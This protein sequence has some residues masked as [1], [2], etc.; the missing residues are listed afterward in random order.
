MMQVDVEGAL[1]Y[2][3][4]GQA[5]CQRQSDGEGFFVF[6]QGLRAP[7]GREVSVSV[8]RFAS[9]TGV[10]AEGPTPAPEPGAAPPGELSIHVALLPVTEDPNQPAPPMEWSNQPGSE[11]EGDVAPDGLSGSVTFRG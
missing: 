4:S 2:A 8:N 6:S 9:E 7:D 5:T 10:P 1:E 3:A 11:I